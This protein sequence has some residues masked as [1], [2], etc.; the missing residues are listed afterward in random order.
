MLHVII[1]TVNSKMHRHQ[2][3]MGKGDGNFDIR[4]K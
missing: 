4:I 1:R 3:R 2:R